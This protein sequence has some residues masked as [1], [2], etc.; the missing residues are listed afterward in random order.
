[1]LHRVIRER[2]S[3]TIWD[4]SGLIGVMLRL[5]HCGSR[6]ARLSY[7]FVGPGL[8]G[9]PIEDGTSGDTEPP[10]AENC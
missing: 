6:Q 5:E 7:R 1:M 9:P 10:I 3:I 4:D 8:S 2:E